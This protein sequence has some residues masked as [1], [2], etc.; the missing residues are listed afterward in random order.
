[1]QLCSLKRQRKSTIV[2]HKVLV[3]IQQSEIYRSNEKGRKGSFFIAHNSY[4]W[5]P[6]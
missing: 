6:A 4:R 5:V 1:M 3:V 2:L